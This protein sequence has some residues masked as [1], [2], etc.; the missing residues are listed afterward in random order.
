VERRLDGQLIPMNPPGGD[1]FGAVH[2]TFIPQKEPQ[3]L[4]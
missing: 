2:R 1:S 4:T 3:D